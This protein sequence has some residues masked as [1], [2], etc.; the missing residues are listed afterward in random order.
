MGG[1]AAY[2]LR[3]QPRRRVRMTPNEKA[4]IEDLFNRLRSSAPSGRDAEA[5]AAIAAEMARSPGAAYALVQTVLVQDHALREAHAKVQAAE[6]AGQQAP[7]APQQPAQP[8]SMLERA[9]SALQGFGGQRNQ[10]QPGQ[11]PPQQ[12]E[13]PARGGGFLQGALQTAAGV[14]G[15]ALLFEGVR[16]MFGGGGG[17]FGGGGS[18]PWG[19]GNTTINETIINENGDRGR[20]NDDN[21]RD[22]SYD[23]DNDDDGDYGSDDSGDS[24]DGW[25]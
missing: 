13:Q 12:A 25:I 10:A 20:D 15:G 19:E 7:Q 8:Q 4:L 21:V 22:A 23:S 2:P 14:A 5:E 24:D 3:K 11:F 16:S 9:G 6:T 18:A 17:L 1:V